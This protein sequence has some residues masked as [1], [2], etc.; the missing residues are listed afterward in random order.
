VGYNDPIAAE[1]A[2]QAVELARVERNDATAQHVWREIAQAVDVAAAYFEDS[3]GFAPT[4]ALAA[5]SIGADG[6]NAMLEGTG[7][8]V[9][10]LVDPGA[11]AAGAAT[12][13]VA[14]GLLAGVRGALR[15]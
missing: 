3:L 15:G 2:M 1:A 5:G 14:R 8:K 10:E 12:A 11:L 4:T 9:R 7:L 13:Q 6:L